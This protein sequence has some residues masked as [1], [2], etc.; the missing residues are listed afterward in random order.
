MSNSFLPGLDW[1][2]EAMLKRHMEALADKRAMARHMASL[3]DMAYFKS[4]G[5]GSKEVA[6]M[7]LAGGYS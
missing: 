5:W 7:K 3:A 6:V 2:K 4:N 1:S